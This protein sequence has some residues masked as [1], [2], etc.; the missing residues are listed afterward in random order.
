MVS[1]LAPD[2]CP[3]CLES[4]DAREQQWPRCRHKFHSTCIKDWRKAEQ[5]NSR[6]CPNCRGTDPTA[7]TA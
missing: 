2:L 1:S 7:P 3:I 6:R 5:A 4:L